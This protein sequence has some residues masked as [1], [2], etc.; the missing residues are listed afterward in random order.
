[1][2]NEYL[3]ALGAAAI[4]AAVIV[5]TFKAGYTLGREREIRDRLKTGETNG[6]EE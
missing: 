3:F 4:F 2:G 6:K 1:M 5:L